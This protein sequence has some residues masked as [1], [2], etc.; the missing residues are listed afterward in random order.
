M[1]QAH[2]FSGPGKPFEGLTKQT[3]AGRAVDLDRRR[4]VFE[5]MLLEPLSWR[6]PQRVFVQRDERPVP[7]GPAGRVH[8]PGVRGD[9]ARAVTHVPVADQASLHVRY[10]TVGEISV[11]SWRIREAGHALNV[12]IGDDVNLALPI[13]SVWLGVSVEDQ[14]H[15]DERIPLFARTPAAVR[16]I[17]AEP[18]SGAIA[19]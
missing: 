19:P 6:K 13:R 4:A 8:R 17:S 16:F 18:L 14:N 9:G 15:A 3:K 10:G 7:R 5:D 12:R 1:K 11:R 2:P